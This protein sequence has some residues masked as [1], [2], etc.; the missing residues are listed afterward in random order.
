ML[1]RLPDVFKQVL[2][3]L[4]DTPTDRA[5]LGRV[6]QACRAEVPSWNNTP[7]KV[8]EFVGSVERLDWAQE[9]GC[10]WS[11]KTCAEAA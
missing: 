8:N 10:P 4:L 11:A 1:A 5:M 9:N 2:L 6:S 3:P 7:L